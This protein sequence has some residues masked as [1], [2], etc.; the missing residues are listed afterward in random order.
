[1]NTYGA[2]DMKLNS[3]QLETAKMIDFQ[4]SYLVHDYGLL[5]LHA[6]WMLLPGLICNLSVIFCL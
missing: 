2:F 1:M 5:T 6:H 3:S 4:V